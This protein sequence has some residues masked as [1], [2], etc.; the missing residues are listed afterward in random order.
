MEDLIRDVILGPGASCDVVITQFGHHVTLAS[1][2][3]AVIEA[4]V[5]KTTAVLV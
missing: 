2:P 4:L 1:Q 5:A 3:G